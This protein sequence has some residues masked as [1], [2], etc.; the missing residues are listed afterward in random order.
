MRWLHPTGMCM[1]MYVYVCLCM[2]VYACVCLCML[3]YACVC[4]NPAIVGQSCTLHQTCAASLETVSGT[5][6]LTSARSSTEWGLSDCAST[7]CVC[8]RSASMA[9]I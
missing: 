3:V 9:A 8:T 2:F 7:S 1:S 4:W 5:V 6:S